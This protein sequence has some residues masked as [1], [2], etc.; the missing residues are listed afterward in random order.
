MTTAATTTIPSHVP[1]ELVRTFPFVLG[2]LTTENPF[3]RMVHDI[4][5]IDPPVFYV[6][7]VYPGG[8][9][10][11]VV[12]RF[13]DLR[14]IYSD[15][16]HFSVKGFAPFARM[17]GENWGN[18][19]AEADAPLHDQYRALLNP[20]FT[21]AALKKLEGK[22]SEIARALVAKFRDT[23]RVEFRSAFAVP[24]PV[25]IVLDLLGLPQ[26][27]MD[28]FMQWEHGLLHDGNMEN[29]A[30]ATRNVVGM[31][32]QI[33]KE[34]RGKPGE[35]LISFALNARLGDRPLTDDEIVGF[36]F[37]LF[38]GG[39]DTVTTNLCWQY[40]H[41]AEH[42]EQQRALR[43]DPAL[44]PDAIQEL[45][46]AYSAASTFRT[47]IKETQIGGVTI[48][49]GDK[50]L[51]CTTLGSNDP[52]VFEHPEEVRFSR[53]PTHLAFGSGIHHCLGHHLARRELT[54]A[55]QTLL[56]ALPEFRLDS[57]AEIVTDL[58]GVIQPRSVPLLWDR[59]N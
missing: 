19:P 47:C 12:R 9:P 17:I 41:L 14:D 51:M 49:P 53:N 37:N 21:P 11:W 7:N 50:V 16:E 46:R 40:R 4:H 36:C 2:N 48:K 30:Q 58:G 13:A 23:G 55:M 43:N 6:P 31:F 59:P 28:E 8:G 26:E 25:S 38:I 45:L 29:L 35:D 22:V 56:P 34:R 42:P 1:R 20:L 5:R 15:A 10:G 57:K 32:R 24:F 44:I 52:E 18:I 3:R 27:R 54:I 33:M 39:L